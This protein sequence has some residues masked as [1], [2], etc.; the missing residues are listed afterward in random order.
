MELLPILGSGMA[1]R[2]LILES[3]HYFLCATAKIILTNKPAY[4]MELLP[5]KCV[6]FMLFR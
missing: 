1:V 6:G 5:L 4:S 3:S 2:A